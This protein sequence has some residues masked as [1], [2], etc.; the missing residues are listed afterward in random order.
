M[1]DSENILI[2]HSIHITILLLWYVVSNL[3]LR[4]KKETKNETASK[5]LSKIKAITKTLPITRK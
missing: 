5:H 1:I 2:V 3:Y 4:E